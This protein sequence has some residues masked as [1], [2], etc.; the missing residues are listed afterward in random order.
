MEV[1]GEGTVNPGRY[2]YALSCIAEGLWL[3]M[4]VQTQVLTLTVLLHLRYLTPRFQPTRLCWWQEARRVQPSPQ[5]LARGVPKPWPSH[6]QQ[7]RP[8]HCVF[9]VSITPGTCTTPLT[10]SYASVLTTHLQT[11]SPVRAGFTL[12]SQYRACAH[13]HVSF[14]ACLCAHKC[15]H[16][17][18]YEVNK[19]LLN[20]RVNEWTDRWASFIVHFY[21]IPVLKTFLQMLLEMVNLSRLSEP[22]DH[23]WISTKEASLGLG[24]RQSVL[25][26]TPIPVL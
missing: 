25:A 21:L 3:W 16:T 5:G 20:K 9:C 10:L 22:A 6:Q 8:H 23:I 15:A 26:Q 14:R 2:W 17:H 12:C 18:H 13:T 4:G 19:C 7:P 1:D 24:E 11:V